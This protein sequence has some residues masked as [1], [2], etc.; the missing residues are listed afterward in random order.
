MSVSR[1]HFLVKGGGFVCLS[2]M[3]GCR[4]A[5]KAETEK[6]QEFEIIPVNYAQNPI[7]FSK[8]KPLVSV[9][10]VNPKWSHGKGIDY[11]TSKALD[12]IGGVGEVT[13]GK[14][15]ILL[16]PNLVSHEPSDTTNPPV[17]EALVNLMKKAGKDVSIGEAG[18]ASLRNIRTDVR[19]YV[20]RTSSA[21]MLKGIQD[22]IFKSTGYDEVSKRTGVPLINLHV[23]TMAK[24]QVPDNFVYKDIFIHKA[25][26]DA[27]LVCSVPMMKT[28]GLAGVTLAMKNIGIGGYPGLIYGTVRSQVHLEGI[29]VEPTG[30]ASVTIDM[31]KANKLGLSLI[32][33]TMAMEGQG[34]SRS[35]GGKLVKMNILIASQNALAADMVAANVMGIEPHEIET[36]KWAW[37]AG[38]GPSTLDE[39]EVVGESIASVRRPF[40]RAQVV[41]YTAL[42]WYGPPC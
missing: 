41:P 40:I 3:L 42:K 29:K 4:P 9:V 8:D 15:R 14:T 1:R 10:K 21:S 34:P 39:I 28:H 26:S 27:D 33:G 5:M 2:A 35:G 30:T 25:L 36:F 7:L 32:D 16:K 23:G 17:I 13:R 22:D 37:K 38:M 12:L 19:G 20:C 31:V 18:A 6:E 11:A 24:M